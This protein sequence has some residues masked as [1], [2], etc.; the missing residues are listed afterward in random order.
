LRPFVV[1]GVACTIA[2]GLVAAVTRPLDL[3][4]GSWLAA[5]LVLVGGVAQ[6]ALGVGQAWLGDELPSRRVRHVEL[7]CWTAGMAAT[8]AGSLAD[9]PLL[10]SLGGLALAA[11][12]VLFLAATGSSRSG[13]RWA[14]LSYRGVLLLVLLSTPVGLVLAWVRHG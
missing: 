2:G 4:L 1:S 14:T 3:G 9:R 12:L 8:M 11:A 7:A 13:P 5:F 10:T 6:T